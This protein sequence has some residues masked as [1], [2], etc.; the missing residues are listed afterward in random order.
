MFFP[1]LNEF[2]LVRKMMKQ[3]FCFEFIQAGFDPFPP[4]RL[5][6]TIA[7]NK[8]ISLLQP[9]MIFLPL[10]DEIIF[11][12]LLSVAWPLEWGRICVALGFHNLL[13]LLMNEMSPGGAKLGQGKVPLNL[14]LACGV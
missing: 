13:V 11:L 14:A 5:Q 7:S 6:K 10:H 2:Y 8:L 4:L 1:W 12:S 9:L 3:L